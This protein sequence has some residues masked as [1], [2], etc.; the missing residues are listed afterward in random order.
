ML[1]VILY[2]SYILFEDNWTPRFTY[3]ERYDEIGV[4]DRVSE[5]LQHG[6]RELSILDVGCSH[7]VA[8]RSLKSTL[9][10]KG[11]SVFV[12]GID[13]SFK[14]KADAE[15]NL[16][17]FINDDVVNVDPS[18]YPADI[19]VL[20]NVVHYLSAKKKATMIRKCA[21]FLRDENSILI[22]NTPTFETTSTFH[23]S[24]IFLQ[25]YWKLHESVTGGPRNFYLHLKA[26]E[27]ERK[28][29]KMFI[30]KG[31]EAANRYADKILDTWE[32]SSMGQKFGWFAEMGR[33][34]FVIRIRKLEPRLLPKKR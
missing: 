2:N 7:G 4:T 26:I 24:K 9:L 17:K 3:P 8:A 33:I 5:N 6:I 30:F 10:A 29:R 18:L 1:S 27:H 11:M 14:V 15:R 23:D 31:K 20:C 34:Q 12:T 19:V 25:D 22:T 16:D 28:L 13:P 32:A 21:E